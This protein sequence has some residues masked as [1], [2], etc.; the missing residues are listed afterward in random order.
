LIVLGLIFE[1]AFYSTWATVLIYI[2]VGIYALNTIFCLVTLPVELNAS[3]RAYKMLVGTNE[4]TTD[5]ANCAKK[6]LDAAALT[7]V[8]ALITSILSLVR[9]LLFIFAM[10]GDRN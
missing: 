2:G 7:Y 5:E 10:R 6:V 3:K 4:M 8:A 9:V 1:I